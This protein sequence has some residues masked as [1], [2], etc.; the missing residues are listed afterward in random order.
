MVDALMCS[1][2]VTQQNDDSLLNG[3]PLAA[4]G[5]YTSQ[6][7]LFVCKSF[8]VSC[9]RNIDMNEDQSGEIQKECSPLFIESASLPGCL[10]VVVSP[11]LLPCPGIPANPQI[12]YDS[13]AWYPLASSIHQLRFLYGEYLA[14]TSRHSGPPETTSRQLT[15]DTLLASPNLPTPT[16]KRV[17]VSLATNVNGNTSVTNR[18]GTTPTRTERKVTFIDERIGWMLQGGQ[19]FSHVLFLH[20]YFL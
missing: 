7:L 18:F 15:G 19:S 2:Q 17:H 3:D 4:A 13:P 9:I 1:I 10:Q 5:L 8:L 20:L 14:S 6:E 16:H 11:C 12:R